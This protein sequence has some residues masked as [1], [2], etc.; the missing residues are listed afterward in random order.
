MSASGGTPA[1]LAMGG[2]NAAN[3]AVSPPGDRL[4]YE[5]RHLDTNIWKIAVPSP[6]RTAPPPS[7]LIASTRQEGGP[8]FSPDGGRI[9]V[10]LGPDRKLRDLGV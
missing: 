6:T 1:R 9:R 10:P 3:P 5:Q 2:D 7:Q 4:A 8:Q